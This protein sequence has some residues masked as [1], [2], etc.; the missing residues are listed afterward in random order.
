MQGTGPGTTGSRERAEPGVA[1]GP[2][3]RVATGAHVAEQYAEARRQAEMLAR[4]RNQY[5]Q[6]V[7][8]GRVRCRSGQR[9]TWAWYN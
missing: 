3:Q 6:Q 9:W 7:G 2:V 1:T 4:A 8:A 5:F